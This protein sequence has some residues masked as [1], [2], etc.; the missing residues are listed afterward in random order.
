MIFTKIK[1]VDDARPH[2]IRARVTK[3][4]SKKITNG[5]TMTEAT[6]ADDTGSMQALWFSKSK[7]IKLKL[8]EE[9]VFTGARKAQYGRLSLFQPKFKNPHEYDEYRKGLED[10]RKAHESRI[11]ESNRNFTIGVVTVLL[12]GAL[13]LGVHLTPESRRNGSACVDVT[14]IDQNWGND[15]RCI[16]PEG[17]T[18]YTDYSGGEKYDSSFR[19]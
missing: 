19:R 10:H 14:S 18:F 7:L 11:A 9:Y 2:V 4:T 6:I 3:M 12:I 16:T 1:D 13:L 5:N 8:N 17:D 15:V